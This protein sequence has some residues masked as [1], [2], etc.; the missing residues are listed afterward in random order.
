M[1]LFIGDNLVNIPNSELSSRYLSEGIE[2]KVYEYKGYALKIHNNDP[3]VFKLSEE[4]AIKLSKIP[5]KRIMMPKHIVRNKNG[6]YIGYATDFKI[7]EKKERIK[8]YTM[9]KLVQELELLKKD[10]KV[11]ADNKVFIDD[12]NLCNLLLSDGFYLCDPGAYSF[13][14]DSNPERIYKYNIIELNYLF[15]R[16]LFPTYLGLTKKEKEKLEQLFKPTS[17][18]FIDELRENVNIDYK[19]K[20]KPYIK[21]LINK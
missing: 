6:N 1:E 7:E 16:L 19:Q 14:K 3:F 17:E 10:I 15:T 8:L 4:N 18:L 21:G 11:L 12:L 5:T 13:N 20:V 2:G 9:E